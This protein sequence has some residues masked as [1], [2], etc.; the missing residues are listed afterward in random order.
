[1]AA[2]LSLRAA[3]VATP[4]GPFTVVRSRVGVVMTS[5]EDPAGALDGARER[6]G[7]AIMPADRPTAAAA[8]EVERYFDGRLRR[9]RAAVDL[10]G[11]GTPFT[12]AVLEV[13]RTIP[14]AELWSYGDVAGAA[15]RPRAA[16][17]AGSALARSPIELFVPAHRVVGVGGGLGGYGGNEDRK[18]A[19]LRLEGVDPG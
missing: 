7:S 13:V 17:A 9:F 6:F 8:R 2:D 16:R 4:L 19:L 1:V 5:G 12:I 15:G 18:R 10:A 3:T 14:Y 11:A